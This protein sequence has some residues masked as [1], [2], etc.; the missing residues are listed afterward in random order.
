MDNAELAAEEATFH[1][2]VQRNFRWNFSVNVVEGAFFWLGISFAAPST[3]IPLYVSHLTDSRV[4]IGLI[5][6]ISGAGWYLP[7]LLTANYVERLPLKKPMVVNVG[8]FSERLPFLAMAASAL[9]FASRSPGLALWLVLLT[10]AWHTL[11]AGLIA[12]AWQEMVA[13]VIPVNYRGRLLGLAN[14]GGN[15][16]GML[17]AVLAAAIL[18]RLPFPANFALCM[19][20]TFVFVMCSWLLVAQTREPPLHS[21]KPQIGLRE[22]AQRLPGVLRRD[23]NFAF[24]LLSRVTGIFGKMGIGF[25]TVYAVQRWRLTDSQAGLYTTLLLAGQTVANLLAG[26]MADRF[27]HKLVLEISLWLCALGMAVAVWAPGPAWMYLVFAAIGGLNAADIVSG[28]MLPLEFTGPDERP[29]Y[30]GLANTIPGLFAAVAPIL[31]GWL[32]S[33]AGYPTLFLVAGGAS[34][35]AWGVMHCMVREPRRGTAQNQPRTQQ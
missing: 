8:F 5:A 2:Q 1:E 35:M 27:G 34:L 33:R 14:F 32:A 15:A 26:V 16:T 29:T 4:A 28:I 10:L 7:Q 12:I 22:Y 25:L 3:I 24:Y 6:A 17:G 31:G 18:A 11:G 9:L 23:H 30:I 20:L 21:N 13:K 19:L